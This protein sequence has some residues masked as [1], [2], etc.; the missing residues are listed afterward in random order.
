MAQWWDDK[1]EDWVLFPDPP[2]FSTYVE[3][4]PVV[5]QLLDHKGEVLFEFKTRTEVEFGFQRPS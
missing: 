5:M 3:P 2:P 1:N 4:N